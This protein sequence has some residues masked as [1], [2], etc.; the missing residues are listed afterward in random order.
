MLWCKKHASPKGLIL[1]IA[2]E[3]L[4]DQTFEEG[5]FILSVNKFFKGELVETETVSD[6][7][8][9]VKI[10]NAVGEEAVSLI[11]GANLATE[12]IVKRVSGI[13][14]LQVFKINS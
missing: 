3:D 10:I 11:I 8:E 2:D 6:M 9:A 4:M 5:D 7:F 1:A 12:D 14:H 13:P